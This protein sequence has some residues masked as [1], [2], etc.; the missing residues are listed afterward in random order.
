MVL[1]QLG[2]TL[3]QTRVE[4]EHLGSVSCMFLSHPL[5]SHHQGKPHDQEDDEEAGTFVGK[6][7]PAWTDRRR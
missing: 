7:R 2:G 5:Y 6:L 1:V 3:E 4:V